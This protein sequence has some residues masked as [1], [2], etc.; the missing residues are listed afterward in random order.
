MYNEICTSVGPHPWPNPK[1]GKP[2]TQ[3]HLA[4]RAL[5]SLSEIHKK[6]YILKNKKFVKIVP[7]NIMDLL[8]A[9][10]IGS[11]G[12]GYWDSSSKTVILCTDNF[13]LKEV[14]L[15]PL[16]LKNTQICLGLVST[17]Q[18]RIKA[19]K[20]VCWR[21]RFSAKSENINKLINLVQPFFIPSM[22]YKLNIDNSN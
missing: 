5:P 4:S 1:T 7:L 3:Y 6:W 22:L 16:V 21:I 13:T 2:V 18:K 14:E 8:T 17:I 12:D 20:E 10:S 11:M 9:R 15:L 19:N